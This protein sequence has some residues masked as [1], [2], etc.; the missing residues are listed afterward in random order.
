KIFD[1]K[2]A[3]IQCLLVRPSRKYI[4]YYLVKFTRE[5]TRMI[6]IILLANRVYGKFFIY[7]LLVNC[8]LNFFFV[9]TLIHGSIS[10]FT[11][12]FIGFYAF[13][14]LW[15]IFV[16]HL[17]IANFNRKIHAPSRLFIRLNMYN[18]L[19]NRKYRIKLDN[20]IHA[21]HTGKRYGFTYY[22]MGRISVF[23]FVKVKISKAE[24]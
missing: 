15:C 5:N 3:Q 17:L 21:F 20:Y 7:F 10:G 16:I 13:S 12:L 24:W 2:L 1:I 22:T 4:N 9:S 8:P 14:Q 18:K 19:V 23:S 11:S 6:S